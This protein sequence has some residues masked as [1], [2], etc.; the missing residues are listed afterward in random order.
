MYYVVNKD[1]KFVDIGFC[2]SSTC[3]HE[4]CLRHKCHIAERIFTVCAFKECPYYNEK[5]ENK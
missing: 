1:D 3:T 2:S 5:K 4:E